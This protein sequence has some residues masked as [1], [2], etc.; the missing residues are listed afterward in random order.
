VS[1]LGFYCRQVEYI[2]H[3]KKYIDEGKTYSFS[4]SEVN[5]HHY[6]VPMKYMDKF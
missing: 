3:P 1:F 2:A 6:N 5:I 4:F